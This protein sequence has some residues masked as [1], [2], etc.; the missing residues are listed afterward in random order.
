M[1]IGIAVI[2]GDAGRPR[3][4]RRFGAN[5]TLLALKSNI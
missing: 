2:A 4:G 5:G 1:D 3:R